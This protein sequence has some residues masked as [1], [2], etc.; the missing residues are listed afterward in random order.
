MKLKVYCCNRTTLGVANR[1]GSL[2]VEAF[3]EGSWFE[4][5]RVKSELGTC[6]FP[7]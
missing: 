1:F 5:G 7:D 6:Y 4:P 3:A 2:V